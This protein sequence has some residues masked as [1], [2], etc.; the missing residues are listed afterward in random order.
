MMAVG[1]AGVVSVVANVAPKETAAMCAAALAGDFKKARGLHLR[2]F[3]L[4]KALFSE[5]NPI[6]VKAAL[7]MMG[8]C[9]G[10]PRLPLTVLSAANRLLLRRELASRGLL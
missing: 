10:T 7:E 6:P 4:V 5:T 9:G 8:L 2:L 1:A 3:P